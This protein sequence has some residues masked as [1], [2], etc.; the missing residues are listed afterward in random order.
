MKENTRKNKKIQERA[1]NNSPV[2]TDVLSVVV[3]PRMGALGLS[4]PH[5]SADTTANIVVLT[6][7]VRVG[8]PEDAALKRTHVLLTRLERAM[9][10]QRFIND[11]CAQKTERSFDWILKK[12]FD[13]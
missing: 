5:I 11:P 8:E 13:Q 10:K 12:E 3:Y 4:I 6:L 2:D 7:A 9:M 1:A